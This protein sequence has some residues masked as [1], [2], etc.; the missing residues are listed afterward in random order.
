MIITAVVA[1]VV[2][3][4]GGGVTA[5]L[6]ISGEDRPV[7]AEKPGPAD[8]DVLEQRTSADGVMY[9]E[10]AVIDACTLMPASLLEETGF[11]DVARGGHSQTYVPRSVPAALATVKGANDGITACRYDVRQEGRIDFLAISV[12]QEPFSE[13]LPARAIGDDVAATIGGLRAFKAKEKKEGDFFTRIHSADG[14]AAVYVSAG[15]L[16]DN[17]GFDYEAA[18]DRLLEK[19]ALNFAAAP[20]GQTRFA[21]TGRYQ[22][23]PPACD[24]LTQEIF[25]EVTGSEDSGVVQADISENEV[26]KDLKN[27]KYVYVTGQMCQRS[28][29]EWHVRKRGNSLEMDLSI[30]RDATMPPINEPDCDPNSSSRRL[31]G[32][33]TPAPAKIGDGDACAFSIGESLQYSFNVGR[34]TVRLSPYG[35]W[36]PKD[37]EE[38][39][40]KFAPVAQRLADE[41][42]KAIG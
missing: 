8:G 27:G 17:K 39:A 24:I 7:V 4:L 3:L 42:R 11:G 2:V 37:Q 26:L 19:I 34:T 6:L 10:V 30:H 14:S 40:V 1:V 16:N 41:V 29:P 12:E 31:F 5:V 23:V 25:E 22:S 28:T 21:Y 35:P 33:A 18:H 38:F 36:V 9:G 15:R 32:P 20:K 13:P